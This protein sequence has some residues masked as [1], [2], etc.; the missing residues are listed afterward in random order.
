MRP[1][2]LKIRGIGS[3][4]K[5]Q[6][7]NFE[8]LTQEGLFGICGDTGSGKS[9]ILESIIAALY[10]GNKIYKLINLTTKKAKVNFIFDIN[11]RRYE[12]ERTYNTEKERK[13]QQADIWDITDGRVCVGNSNSAVT[14]FVKKLI[15]IEINQFR[16]CVILEQGKYDTFIKLQP[17]E[18][19]ETI[20]NIFSLTRFGPELAEKIKRKK[21]NWESIADKLSGELMAYG[22]ISAEHV[23]KDKVKLNEYLI[24][25]EGKKEEREKAAKELE[26]IIKQKEQYE[27]YLEAKKA[28]EQAMQ[29]IEK[30]DKE[31]A[32]ANEQLKHAIQNEQKLPNLNKEKN[33]LIEKIALIKVQK[34]NQEKVQKLKDEV[35]KL[36]GQAKKLKEK[37]IDDK[38][39]KQDIS[40]I[41]EQNNQATNNILQKLNSLINI[42]PQGDY[43]ISIIV[44]KAYS[45]FSSKVSEYMKISKQ[46]EEE[47]YRLNERR[48]KAAELEKLAAEIQ[49]KETDVKRDIDIAEK[50]YE[51]LRSIYAVELLRAS[52]KGGDACPVCHN[53]IKDDC[54]HASNFDEQ[55]LTQAKEQLQEAK[56]KLEEYKTQLAQKTEQLNN[57]KQNIIELEQKI[58]N[59]KNELDKLG[60]SKDCQF[61]QKEIF[62]CKEAIIKYTQEKTKQE[63][64]LFELESEIKRNEDQYN[65][66]KEVGKGKVEEINAFNQEIAKHLPPETDIDAALEALEKQ[67]QALEEDIDKTLK[68]KEDALKK[69]HNLENDKHSKDGEAKAAKA[70]ADALKCE[71]PVLS[72]YEA[73]KD[74]LEKLNKEI[75]EI[76]Q[77]VGKLTLSVEQGKANLEKKIELEKKYR[78]AEEQLKLIKKLFKL[79]SANKLMEFVAEEY[80]QHFTAQ[81]SEYLSTL[82]NGQLELTYDDK[83]LI[84][85]NF[86]G[87]QTR[88]IDSVSGGET[89]LVSLSI[90]ISISQAMTMR[91]GANAIEFLFIDEGFGTLDS[92]LIDIV[93]D[94]LERLRENFVIGLISHRAELQARLP[95]KLTVIKTEEEGSHI[96]H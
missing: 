35:D 62:E 76:T 4:I 88:E 85:D 44:E 9:T 21:S 72:V 90:A 40:F 38:K 31:L 5:E 55:S 8:T 59:L 27:K 61:M 71:Q 92:K 75:E 23:E 95:V 41:L 86:N 33:E 3:F 26:L 54:L 60:L 57:I 17:A 14:D 30:L 34:T 58:N 11:G 77:E 37:I 78:Q 47:E 79:A 6:E 74:Y 46:I 32:V 80:I 22:N 82:T 70:Q 87:G 15:G 56:S 91:A 48:S 7:I 84:I 52:L 81:A 64:Q 49:T 69:A 19:K 20:G 94:A 2:S 42:Q 63:K 53:I 68:S 67:R 51:E 39:A 24:R 66:I 93:M 65:N 13:T 36:R 73:K 89:F 1:I 16:Q 25:Q 12:V 83:F 18:R 43:E 10:G 50:S 29:E 45:E 96:K 28:Y